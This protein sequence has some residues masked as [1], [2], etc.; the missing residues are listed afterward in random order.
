MCSIASAPRAERG[1][2]APLLGFELLWPRWVVLHE[3][4]VNLLG[5]FADERLS[6]PGENR[7]ARFIVHAHS[8]P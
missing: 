2:D 3:D 5:G 6:A 7:V 1:R 4:D 8:L